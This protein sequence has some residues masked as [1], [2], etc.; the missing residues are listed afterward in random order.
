MGRKIR[1]GHHDRGIDDNALTGY[2]RGI[3]GVDVSA[4]SVDDRKSA[5]H[6]IGSLSNQYVQAGDAEDGFFEGQAVPLY[7]GEPDPDSGE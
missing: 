4:S 2:S 6:I 1:Y 3:C 7:R 5:V